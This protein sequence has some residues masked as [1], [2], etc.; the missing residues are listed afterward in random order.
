MGT[1]G[2]EGLSSASCRRN[3]KN[4][5][6]QQNIGPKNVCNSEKEDKGTLGIKNKFSNRSWGTG[7]SHQWVHVT[8]EVINDIRTTEG[9]LGNGEDRD[10]VPKKS[11]EPA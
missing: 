8:E 3:L 4:S 10:W 5:P 7:Q 9:K 1:T 11:N 6:E 2:R